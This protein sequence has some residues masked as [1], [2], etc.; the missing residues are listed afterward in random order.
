MEEAPD[1]RFGFGPSD[2]Q[3]LTS[4]FP[5]YTSPRRLRALERWPSWLA[6][7]PSPTQCERCQ[8]ITWGWK[9]ASRIF[10]VGTGGTAQW[11]RALAALPDDWN[12]FPSTHCGAYDHCD[13]RF[14]GS[15]SLFWHPCTSTC[16]C[17][18]TQHF[19]KR[20]SRVALQRERVQI[21]N[22]KMAR[23]PQGLWF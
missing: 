1:L 23:F 19:K 4:S 22:P 2:F 20:I 15:H 8:S 5:L 13:S 10:R 21:A 18:C 12:L 6:E 14:R 3:L 16:T 9:L 7:H 11:W 17:K